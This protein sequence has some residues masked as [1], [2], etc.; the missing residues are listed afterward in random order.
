MITQSVHA[1]VYSHKCRGK[2]AFVCACVQC[3]THVSIHPHVL[4]TFLILAL[5]SN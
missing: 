1:M 3:S 4:V 2:H 5:K